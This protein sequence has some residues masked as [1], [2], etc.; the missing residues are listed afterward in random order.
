[1]N[2]DGETKMLSFVFFILAVV[3]AAAG[4]LLLPPGIQQM[5][6]WAAA[7]LF[8]VLFAISLVRKSNRRTW[9]GD[10]GGRAS[11]SEAAA[12]EMPAPRG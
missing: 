9:R 11:S 6:A 12:E 7:V 2:P 1:L 10:A 5:G 4:F 8:L 3:T